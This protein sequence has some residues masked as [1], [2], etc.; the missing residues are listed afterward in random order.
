[1]TS[2]HCGR[3]V[4]ASVWNGLLGGGEGRKSGFSVCSLKFANLAVLN[5]NL[6]REDGSVK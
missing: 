2:L 4:G 3:A 5:N 1:M 6:R